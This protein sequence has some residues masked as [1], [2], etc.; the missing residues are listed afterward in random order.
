[1]LGNDTRLNPGTPG[2]ANYF[3]Q[4]NSGNNGVEYG[5]DYQRV[6]II[7]ASADGTIRLGT[8]P[9]VRGGVITAANMWKSTGTCT[10][11]LKINTTAVTGLSAVAVTTSEGSDT[12]AT[13]ANVVAGA[14][15]INLT[16][17]SDS[18]GGLIMVEIE[19]YKARATA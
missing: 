9:S 17:S 15:E 7:K 10:A 11:A 1:V 14:D 6:H 19:Y 2:D 12:A 4:R 3:V 16:I 8:F 13:A 18:G 5:R